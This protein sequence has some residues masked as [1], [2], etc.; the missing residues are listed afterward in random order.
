MKDKTHL[1]KGFRLEAN[2]VQQDVATLLNIPSS[3]L[4]R[5]E[6]EKHKPTPEIILT[7]H[8]LFDAP[9]K[10]LFQ[11][12]YK[13]VKSNIIQ[14]SKKLITQLEIEQTPKSKY[15]VAYLK[16]I[17]KRLNTEQDYD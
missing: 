4:N 2:V 17:V 1:L 15:R 11:P 14:R 3:N 16:D 8:I 13:K 6:K 10:L 12:L 5:Y 7:Y 9:L